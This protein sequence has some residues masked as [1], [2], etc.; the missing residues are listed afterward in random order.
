MYTTW[1]QIAQYARLAGARYPEIVAAMWALESNWGLA[2]SGKYNYFG[3]MGKKGTL[4]TTSEYINNKWIVTESVF[5]DFNSVEECVKY[6]VDK[7]FVDY[8]RESDKT[9]FKGINRANTVEEAAAM[10]VSE[11]YATDPAYKNKI[12]GII[13]TNAVPNLDP[14]TKAKPKFPLDVIYYY[15]RDSKTGHGERSCQSSAIAM[16]IE[17][18]N[19]N[20][21]RD[22]DDY[23]NL[24]FKY[25]DTVSQSAHSKAISRLGLNSSFKTNGSAADIKAIL[26]KGY[27]VPIGILHKG[28][29]SNPSGGGHWITLIGYD[30]THFHVHDPFGE[31]DLINGGYPKA[32]PLDGKNKR[33][34]I[35]NLMKR[36]LI[37]SKTDGWYWDLSSNKKV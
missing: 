27:P 4:R 33:Y 11:G 6:L 21:I 1:G 29:I 19:A 13:K 35:N 17:Y 23:L 9:A 34:T 26:D 37:A 32:G 15:Q 36:W 7:W 20:L 22:D 10:L 12:L 3:L 25:G 16:V 2:P 30:A 5:L 18:I 28:S 31:L 14:K 8:F 24:V